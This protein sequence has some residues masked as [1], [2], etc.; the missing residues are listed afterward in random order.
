[1]PHEKEKKRLLQGKC[2]YRILRQSFAEK[3]NYIS[4]PGFGLR[5]TDFVVSPYGNE[6]DDNDAG[7]NDVDLEEKDNGDNK[8]FLEMK[9]C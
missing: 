4:N 9:K 7:G 6:R 5:Q 2:S 8:Y 3:F 1:M